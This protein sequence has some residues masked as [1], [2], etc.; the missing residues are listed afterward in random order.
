MF[1]STVT[2]Y[3]FKLNFSISSSVGYWRKDKGAYKPIAY[4]GNS[5]ISVVD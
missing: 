4:P 3:S 1:I 2:V 5:D